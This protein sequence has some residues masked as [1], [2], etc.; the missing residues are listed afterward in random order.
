[1]LRSYYGQPDSNVL[2]ARRDFTDDD[3][4]TWEL[5]LKRE[6]TLPPEIQQRLLEAAAESLVAEQDRTSR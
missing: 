2:R 6:G 3:L 1:M 5:Q 4:L